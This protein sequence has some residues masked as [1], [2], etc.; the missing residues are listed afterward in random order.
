M[1]EIE[2]IKYKISAKFLFYYQNQD[3]HKELGFHILKIFQAMET[4]RLKSIFEYF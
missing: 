1:C 2:S 4:L 3:A